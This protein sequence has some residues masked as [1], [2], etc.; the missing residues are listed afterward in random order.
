VGSTVATCSWFPPSPL[1][2]TSH[3]SAYGEG[4]LL[5]QVMR[6]EPPLCDQPCGTCFTGSCIPGSEACHPHVPPPFSSH[7]QCGGC[8]V[9]HKLVDNLN[10]F[11]ELQ[12]SVFLASDAGA[13]GC[14]V[15]ES[16]DILGLE[17]PFPTLP[18][19]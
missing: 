14:S 8:L 11:H 5:F 6:T 15:R 16:V 4:T 18:F 13:R 3:V 19:H 7:V 9:F 2:T 10:L 17:E 1:P 12:G